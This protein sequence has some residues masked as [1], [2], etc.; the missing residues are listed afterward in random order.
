M[1]RRAS[2]SVGI[3]VRMGELGEMVRAVHGHVLWVHGRLLLRMVLLVVRKVG[4]TTH[5]VVGV[6]I[7]KKT[8][9]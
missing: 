2:K 7:R 1:L 5:A 9:G 6:A 3:V 8:G 4:V